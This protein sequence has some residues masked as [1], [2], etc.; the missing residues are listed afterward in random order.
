MKILIS[1]RDKKTISFSNKLANKFDNLKISNKKPE[2]IISLGGDG[3]YLY[4]ERKYPGIP[5]LLVRDRS[6]CKLCSIYDFKNIDFILNKLNQKKFTILEAVKLSCKFKNK[7]LIGVNDIVIRNKFQYEAIRFNLDI[8]KKSEST[9]LIG[10][11][12][13]ASTSFGSTGYFNNISNTSFTNG[14]GIAF[15]NVSEKKKSLFLDENDIIEFTLLRS[16]AFVSA[17]NNKEMFTMKK[18]DKAIISKSKDK[19]F[20]VFLC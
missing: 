17:D 3:T 13:V 16:E 4:N 10:D 11:G 7:E 14:F 19:A 18:N 6:I 8:N 9:N 20:I 1:G 5:K 2:I 12:I 15:N